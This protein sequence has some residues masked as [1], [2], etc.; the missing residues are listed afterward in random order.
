MSL[1]PTSPVRA[2]HR[3]I[4]KLVDIGGKGGV[5]Y[6]PREYTE[7]SDM[8]I[9]YGGSWEKLFKGSP[10]EVSRLKGLLKFAIKQ[11]LITSK[12]S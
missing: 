11:G 7:L 4:Q 6:L 10:Q 5:V 12:E 3:F 9:R 2:D 8:F 1:T